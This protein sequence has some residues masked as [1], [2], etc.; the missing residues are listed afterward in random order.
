MVNEP[1]TASEL[2]MQRQ[3]NQN[4]QTCILPS[5]AAQ[6]FLYELIE[7]SNFPGKMAEFVSNIKQEIY[8]AQILDS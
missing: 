7:Q 4:K 2:M 8:E 6:Q 3:N 5:K 1:Q